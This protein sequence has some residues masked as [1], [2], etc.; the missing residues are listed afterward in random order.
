MTH[1]PTYSH[2][3]AIFRLR[4]VT[5]YVHPDKATCLPISFLLD[6]VTKVHMPPVEKITYTVT[7]SLFFSSWFLPRVIVGPEKIPA[8]FSGLNLGL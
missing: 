8:G 3:K 6:P 4:L 1:I 2:T 5:A 7:S